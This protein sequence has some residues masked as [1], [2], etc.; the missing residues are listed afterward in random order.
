MPLSHPHLVKLQPAPSHLEIAQCAH[1]ISGQW[2]VADAPLMLLA[3]ASNIVSPWMLAV[4]AAL[5]NLPLVVAGLGTSDEWRWF[6]GGTPKLPGSLRAVQLLNAVRSTSQVPVALV[7]AFDTFVANPV[8]SRLARSLERLGDSSVVLGGEC[9]HY[10]KCNVGEMHD[11]VASYR[12]CIEEGLTSCAPNGG[13][14]IGRP[15]AVEEL[16]SSIL[17]VLVAGNG[18]VGPR[19]FTRMNDQG[20]L[21]Q[22]LIDGMRHVHARIDGASEHVLNLHPCAT[23]QNHTAMTKGFESCRVRYSIPLSRTLVPNASAVIHWPRGSTRKACGARDCDPPV[24]PL[25]VHANGQ[26]A[27]LKHPK[28]APIV[29]KLSAWPP[30]ARVMAMPVLLV[31]ADPSRP[32]TVVHL[33]ELLTMRFG[34]ATAPLSRAKVS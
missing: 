34:N 30:P 5:Q 2:D 8:S 10:P 33:K 6:D 28:L 17:R 11:T 15:Q 9:M 23:R 12:A 32:C 25:L 22:V 1:E 20:A 24:K 18:D 14:M 31:D 16:L 27:L 19:R 4:S 13:Y 26:H 21:H 7:D 29:N 3:Y